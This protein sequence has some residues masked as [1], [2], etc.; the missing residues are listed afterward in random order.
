MVCLGFVCVRAPVVVFYLFFVLSP[1]GGLP[2]TPFCDHALW[3]LAAGLVVGAS[4]GEMVVPLTLTLLFRGSGDVEDG[5]RY[6]LLGVVLTVAG[7]KPRNKALILP[8]PPIP[9]RVMLCLSR[10]N[11][12]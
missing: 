7:K 6:R 8:Q 3:Q 12:F 11:E 1:R 2:L 9:E 5:G 10:K 4:L